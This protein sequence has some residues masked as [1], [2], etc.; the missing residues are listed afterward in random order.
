VPDKNFNPAF[1]DSNV[2]VLSLGVGLTCRLGGRFL[3]IKDCGQ[4]D[5]AY[6]LR[7]LIGLDLAYQLFLFEPRTVT[8]NPNP[9]VN[10]KYRTTNQ[11]LTLSFRLGF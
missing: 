5:E 8:G 3:G 11:A 10:G 2:H 4:P 1:P 7:K 9:A 6:S